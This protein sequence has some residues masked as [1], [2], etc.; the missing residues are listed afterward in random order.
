MQSFVYRCIDYKI[1]M[2]VTITT[3]RITYVPFQR[4]KNE[5][6]RC[7]AISINYVVCSFI[8]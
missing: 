1:T 5:K 3:V 4:Y 7:F 2:T 6:R 8:Y